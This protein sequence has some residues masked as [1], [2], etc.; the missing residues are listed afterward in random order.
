LRAKPYSKELT[1]IELNTLKLIACGLSDVSILK[2][3]HITQ[4]GLNARKHSIATRLEAEIDKTFNGFK[5]YSLRNLIVA[6]A[7]QKGI[8]SLDDF[9]EKA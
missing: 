5:Q 7:L 9:R 6:L 1:E 2:Q 3:E 4:R 8:L